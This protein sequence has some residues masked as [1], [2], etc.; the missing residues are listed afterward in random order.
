MKL[1]MIVALCAI[2]GIFGWRAMAQ[3]NLPNQQLEL[4]TNRARHIVLLGDETHI[5]AIKSS[6]R[7][8]QGKS[9]IV[10]GGVRTANYYNFR[11]DEA[12]STYFS[13]DFHELTEDM[14]AIGNLTV[15]ARRSLAQP[16]VDAVLKNEA[17]GAGKIVRLKTMITDRSFDFGNFSENAELIDWQFT[18]ATDGGWEPWNSEIVSAENEKQLAR[19]SEQIEEQRRIAVKMQEQ[20]KQAAAEKALRFNQ[21]AAAKGDAFGLLRMGERYRD[22]DGVEQDLAKAKEYLQKAADAGSPT[23]AEELSKLKQ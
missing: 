7:N 14:K 13:L 12:S 22:G 16:L 21:D 1:G 10:V 5:S 11:Y 15:Y 20:S 4:N 9:I 3:T 23:A 6:P 8:Y 2:V 19:Q 17:A 18:K